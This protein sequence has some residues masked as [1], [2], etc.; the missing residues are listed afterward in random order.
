MKTLINIAK[1]QIYENKTHLL[2][3]HLSNLAIK[4][5]EYRMEYIKHL[6]QKN[7]FCLQYHQY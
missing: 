1:T 6:N 7:S 2:K 4:N 5:K 3:M